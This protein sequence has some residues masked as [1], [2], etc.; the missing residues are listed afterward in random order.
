MKPALAMIFPLLSLVA[1]VLCS[2]WI[3]SA[4]AQPDQA[5][6]QA[7]QIFAD[8]DDREKTRVRNTAEKLVKDKAELQ[9]LRAIHDAI[10]AQPEL[11]GKLDR[12]KQWIA[13][14]DNET[15][16]RL[17]PSGEFAEDWQES[18][19]TEFFNAA[20]AVRE[21]DVLLDFRPDGA[22]FTVTEEQFYQFMDEIMLVYAP[23]DV[24]AQV[25][26]YDNGCAAAL[27]KCNWI[28]SGILGVRQLSP[29][30][31]FRAVD[32]VDASIFRDLTDSLDRQEIAKWED[33]RQ[34][35]DPRRTNSAPSLAWRVIHSGMNH[36]AERLRTQ[37]PS[38]QEE[39][40]VAAYNRLSRDDQI[41]LMVNPDTAHHHLELMAIRE[42][43]DES[44][45]ALLDEFQELIRRFEDIRRRYKGYRGGRG[46]GGQQG[47]G[48][49]RGPERPER[50]EGYRGPK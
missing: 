16:E 36:F 6:V 48:P 4:K 29:S 35:E 38:P 45:R 27:A 50:R 3:A 47:G 23:S 34:K 39:Q 5:E 20:N 41:Q 32:G 37:F 30:Q 18:I 14:A 44:I 11:R 25:N 42:S 33:A 43:G 9:R 26:S 24:Q 49:P 17:K 19:E 13:T 31:M 1:G 46:L 40:I 7:R 10:T 21:I 8:L 2:A 28:A 22:K 12:V 15:L